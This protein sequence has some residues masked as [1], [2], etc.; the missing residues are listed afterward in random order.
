MSIV[1]LHS[2][3]GQV[4]TRLPLHKR[5]LCPRPITCRSYKLLGSSLHISCD[6]LDQFNCLDL[7]LKS[8]WGLYIAPQIE[9][10][11]ILLVA[12]VEVDFELQECL[13]CKT[14]VAECEANIASD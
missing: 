2:S 4:G 5:L 13:N 6:T 9:A 12:V 10:S 7:T 3:L 1:H 8:C 11:R 14:C